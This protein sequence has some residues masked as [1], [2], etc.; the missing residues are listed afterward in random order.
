MSPK[1]AVA[2]EASKPL[3]TAAETAEKVVEQEIEAARSAEGS[4]EKPPEPVQP[5][6]V[7][8]KKNSP[9]SVKKF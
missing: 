6:K 2:V 4:A 1:L 8:V 9:K 7:Y 3:F 5:Q